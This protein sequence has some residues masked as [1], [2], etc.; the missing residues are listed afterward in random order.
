MIAH[1]RT[2]AEDHPDLMKVIGKMDLCDSDGED[3]PVHSSHAVKLCG[4]ILPAGCSYH[5]RISVAG[6]L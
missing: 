5:R 1:N 4:V 3:D 2:A 6:E